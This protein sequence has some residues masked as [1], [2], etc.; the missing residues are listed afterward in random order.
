MDCWATRPSSERL[1][2][3]SIRKAARSGAGSISPGF[4]SRS[5][6]TALVI[7][8]LTEE[9]HRVRDK[10]KRVYAR[11]PRLEDSPK[12]YAEVKLFLTAIEG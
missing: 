12:T 2:L 6:L 9:W 11:L 10:E 5:A 8:D 3:S 1:G 7:V 4:A